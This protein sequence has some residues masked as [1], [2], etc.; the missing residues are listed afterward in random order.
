M[1]GSDLSEV[2]GQLRCWCGRK[3]VCAVHLVC[4]HCFR[5]LSPEQKEMLYLRGPGRAEA[6][7]RVVEDLKRKT[8][9]RLNQRL[10][11]EERAITSSGMGG[12]VVPFPRRV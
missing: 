1:P 8:R 10:Y 11:P 6:Y 5:K 12:R 2:I 4:G 7:D 3:K 9:A